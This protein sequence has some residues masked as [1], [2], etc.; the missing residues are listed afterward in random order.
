M[1]EAPDGCSSTCN[2]AKICSRRSG[3]GACSCRAAG[4]L[5]TNY[6]PCGKERPCSNKVRE[7]YLSYY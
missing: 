1:A 6:C 3:R 5:C 2:P 4:V 7:S